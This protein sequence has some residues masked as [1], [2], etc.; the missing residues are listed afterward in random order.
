MNFKLRGYRY[1]SCIWSSHVINQD[2][3]AGII[4][5]LHVTVFCC[6]HMVGKYEIRLLKN[7]L[8]GENV[9]IK[10]SVKS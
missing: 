5:C 7:L 8:I 1:G 9:R 2:L 4:G 3:V 10:D 6:P